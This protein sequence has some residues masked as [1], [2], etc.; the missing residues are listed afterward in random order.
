MLSEQQHPRFCDKSSQQ[1]VYTVEGHKIKGVV[2]DRREKRTEGMMSSQQEHTTFE[3][4]RKRRWSDDEN[5]TL[6]KIAKKSVWETTNSTRIEC[7]I[8]PPS[9]RRLAC[10][11]VERVIGA[12]TRK[13]KKSH[14]V[15]PM[16]LMSTLR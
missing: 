4:E 16:K 2:E 10:A 14:K 15:T 12:A 13:T 5:L 3:S 7:I 11:H 6:I 9:R 8:R 1:G